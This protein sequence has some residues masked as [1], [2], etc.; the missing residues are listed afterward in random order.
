MKTTPILEPQLTGDPCRS[1]SSANNSREIP[2]YSLLINLHR[3]DSDYRQCRKASATN[4]IIS[5]AAPKRDNSKV[6]CFGA[7]HPA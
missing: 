1:H 7:I 3:E 5:V 4:P 2:G 6:Y